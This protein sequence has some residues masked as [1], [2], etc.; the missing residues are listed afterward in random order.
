MRIIDCES[1]HTRAMTG[2]E[3]ERPI[4]CEGEVPRWIAWPSHSEIGCHAQMQHIAR[5]RR[6][7]FK[8]IMYN[9]CMRTIKGI[10]L[11]TLLT[12]WH[13]CFHRK[14]DCYPKSLSSAWY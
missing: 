1:C 8:S 12:G 14:C 9:R 2:F 4:R 13:G 11:Y 5:W 10:Q 7:S 6:Q 3:R